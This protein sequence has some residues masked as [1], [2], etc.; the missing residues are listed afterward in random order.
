MCL[1]PPAGPWPWAKKWFE[2]DYLCDRKKGPIYP[3]SLD[4]AKRSFCQKIAQAG[5]KAKPMQ[6]V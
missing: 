5:F 4:R 2:W 1:L 6:K 3:E